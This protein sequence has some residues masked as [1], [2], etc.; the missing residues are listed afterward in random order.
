MYRK[1][2]TN[3]YLLRNIL[4]TP[5]HTIES[6]SYGKESKTSITIIYLND[7]VDQAV[8]KIVKERIGAINVDYI[9][10]SRI[11]EDAL[12]GKPLTFFN[13]LMSTDRI[14]RTT[15]AL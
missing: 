11:V 12:E 10:E 7:T 14:D 13:L 5:S 8:L 1:C 2:T 15:S 9:L 6:D 3:I 4:R